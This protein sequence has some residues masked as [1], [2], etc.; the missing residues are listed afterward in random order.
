M[1]RSF[2]IVEQAHAQLRKDGSKERQFC[3]WLWFVRA[4]I[5]RL[6][7]PT[8]ED[9][10]T[11]DDFKVEI[12]TATRKRKAQLADKTKKPKWK[13]G[14]IETLTDELEKRSCLRYVFGKDYHWGLKLIT[15][16]LARFC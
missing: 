9:Y 8:M 12:N 1:P 3:V 10:D 4:I 14:E 7:D 15:R 13:S 5:F 6:A 16:P 2:H 11:P